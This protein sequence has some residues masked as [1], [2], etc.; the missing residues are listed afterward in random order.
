MGRKS[1]LGATS[2]E[3]SADTNIFYYIV[4]REKAGFAPVEDRVIESSQRYGQP[5]DI[6]VIV[7]IEEATHIVSIGEYL[8]V[9][10][11]NEVF[12][13]IAGAIVENAGKLSEPQIFSKVNRD[14]NLV[15]AALRWGLSSG[16]LVRSGTGKKG[17]P[18]VFEL[19]IKY[20]ANEMPD[21]VLKLLK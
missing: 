14:H 7:N 1:V 13:E 10:R 6:P 17:D 5:I 21:T 3:G 19:R 4:K 11:L 16:K 9:E 12:Q 18:F 20:L 8:H 2:I 15:Y